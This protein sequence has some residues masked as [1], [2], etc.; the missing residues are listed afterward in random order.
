[1]FNLA[2]MSIFCPTDLQVRFY[3][4]KMHGFLEKMTVGWRAAF[5]FFSGANSKVTWVR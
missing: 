3:D 5:S 1:M 4:T 2:Q